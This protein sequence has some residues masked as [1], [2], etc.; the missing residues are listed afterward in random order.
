M[1]MKFAI[2]LAFAIGL[3]LCITF[4][5]HAVGAETKPRPRLV[6]QITADQLRGDLP[7][8]YFDRFGEGGFRYLMEQGTRCRIASL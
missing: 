1:W 7:T 6:P 2:K 4:T 3:P 8:R 5:P